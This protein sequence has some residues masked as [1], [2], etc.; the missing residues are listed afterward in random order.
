[1]RSINRRDIFP[2]FGAAALAGIAAAG[3]AKPE[4][5]TAAPAAKPEGQHPDAKLIA[6]CDEFCRLENKVKDLFEHVSTWEDED[7]I[8]K[9]HVELM[10]LQEPLLE[11]ITTTPATTLE[12]LKTQARTMFAFSDDLLPPEDTHYWNERFLRKVL[13]DLL[14]TEEPQTTASA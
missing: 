11:I 7:R 6:A 10:N 14:R 5:L 1:M 12:G 3:L 13:C 4:T 9:Q 2:A 8:E